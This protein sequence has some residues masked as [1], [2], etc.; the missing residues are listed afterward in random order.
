DS[1]AVQLEQVD[2]DPARGQAAVDLQFLLGTRTLAG[3][4]DLEVRVVTEVANGSNAALLLE[5]NAARNPALECL[6]GEH[7]LS[8]SQRGDHAALGPQNDPGELYHQLC[9]PVK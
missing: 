9:T 1:L 3:E 6:I 2:A 8:P 7:S 4:L 5:G